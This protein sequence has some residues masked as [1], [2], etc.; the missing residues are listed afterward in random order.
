MSGKPDSEGLIPVETHPNTEPSPISPLH[1]SEYTNSSFSPPSA[2]TASF[3]APPYE[4]ERSN[5]EDAPMP[6]NAFEMPGKESQGQIARGE[7]PESSS[8]P[9]VA[10]ADVKEYPGQP[11]ASQFQP[12]QYYT[13]FGQPTTY[14]TAIPLHALQSASCPVDC[15][16]CG[17]REMT[18]IESVSGSTTQ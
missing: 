15:P 8:Q 17:K 16:A 4:N 9:P 12:R 10:A 14:A 13:P 3:P 11:V 18:R 7:Q 1:T 2:L 5:A 6:V